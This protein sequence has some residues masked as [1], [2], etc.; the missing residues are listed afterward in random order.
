MPVSD[1]QSTY[2]LSH[3]RTLEAEAVHVMREVGAVPEIAY[4]RDTRNAELGKS[5]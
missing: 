1:R 5:D 4:R 3:L 2:H